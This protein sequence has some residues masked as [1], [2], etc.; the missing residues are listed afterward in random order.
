MRK[1]AS[2]LRSQEVTGPDVG[3]RQSHSV[4]LPAMCPASG[5]P[6]LGS[7]LALMYRPAGWCLEVYSLDQLLQRFVGGWR[8]NEHYPPERNME[9]AC[10]LIA[11][12]VADAV[13]VP[14]R[15]RARLILDT[16]PMR[17]SGTAKPCDSFSEHTI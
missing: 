2:G 12:M 5:N 11:Q 17:L 14:V 4:K 3:L 15:F 10:A 9:G 13:G 6:Q 16:S 7:E 1:H 8:G